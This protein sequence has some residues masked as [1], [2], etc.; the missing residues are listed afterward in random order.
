MNIP[1]LTQIF[2]AS[3]SSM[4]RSELEALR[5]EIDTILTESKPQPSIPKKVLKPLTDR[6]KAIAKG[7]MEKFQF[8]LPINVEVRVGWEGNAV[9]TSSSDVSLDYTLT[10]GK[11][12]GFNPNIEYLEDYITQDALLKLFP[13][14][15]AKMEE[16]K[17]QVKDLVEECKAVAEEYT[18]ASWDVIEAVM[19]AAEQEF[20][21]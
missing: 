8:S 13:E 1:R 12:N 17:K 5:T 14:L 4:A 6:A 7:K 20:F 11:V 2:G 15:K 16:C 3:V 21:K 19:D 10:T 9:P 18:V